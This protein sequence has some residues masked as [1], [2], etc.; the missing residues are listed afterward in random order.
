MTFIRIQD[1]GKAFETAAGT[2]HALADVNLSIDSGE[3]VAIVGKSGS[4]KSTL[5][6][7]V[8]GIDRPSR[9]SVSIGATPIHRLTEDQLAAWRGENV[10][11]V[12]QFFQL[13]PTLTAIENVMLPMD[14][15]GAW[16]PRERRA[17]A[18]RLLE[19][20]ALGDQAGKLPAELSGGEQ[21]RVAIARALANDPPL[22]VADEPTGNLDSRTA[23][24]VFALFADLV[25]RGKTIMFVTHDI[26][27]AAQASRLITLSDGRVVGDTGAS[28]PP[29]EAAGASPPNVLVPPQSAAAAGSRGGRRGTLAQ[30]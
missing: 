4:G 19:D 22:I 18:W 21:Q 30:C 12:F 7:L 10:G 14:F 25:R 1:V 9:G 3:F 28:S 15:R 24:A 13:M 17:R 23:D 16:P 11:V 27:L 26:D 20:V 6:N 5:L 8:A 2:F 29:A